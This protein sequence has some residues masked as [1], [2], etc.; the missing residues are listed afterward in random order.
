MTRKKF[1]PSIY[2][3][4][5]FDLITREELISILDYVLNSPLAGKVFTF[6]VICIF[7]WVL[8]D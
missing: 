5:L 2:K 1:E 6:L 8:R 4:V 3:M 7:V